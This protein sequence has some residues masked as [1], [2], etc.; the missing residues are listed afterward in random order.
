MEVEEAYDEDFPM[1][2]LQLIIHA[3]YLLAGR[4]KMVPL[5]DREEGGE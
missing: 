2:L 3:P 5:P 4:Y 1:D